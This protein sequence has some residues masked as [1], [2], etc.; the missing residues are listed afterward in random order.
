M[1]ENESKIKE[2]LIKKDLLD[3]FIAKSGK[4]KNE[5]ATQDIHKLIHPLSF[6]YDTKKHP[7]MQLIPPWFKNKKNLKELYFKLK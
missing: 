6:S 3:F 7:D 2:K 1:S 5:G 4:L